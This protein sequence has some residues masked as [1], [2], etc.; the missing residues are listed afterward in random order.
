MKNLYNILEIPNDSSKEEIKKSY[1]KLVVKYH[2]D[3]TNNEPKSTEKFKEIQAAY[4]ILSDEQRRKE[5]DNMNSNERI[6]FDEMFMNFI[7]G[8]KNILLE[9]LRASFKLNKQNMKI[10]SEE[11]YID[12]CMSIDE[13]NELDII[14]DIQIEL[15][16]KYL[17]KKKKIR[18]MRKIYENDKYISKEH[19]ITI[20]L[21]DNQIILYELGDEKYIN[22]N[23]QKGNLIINILSKNNKRYRINE[24]DLIKEVNISLYEYFYGIKFEL[25]HFDCKID[26]NISTPIHNLIHNNDKLL[27]KI[28]KKGLMK[29]NDRG[30]LYIS[31]ILNIKNIGNMDDRE[32]LKYYYPVI[33]K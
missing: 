18:Y 26:I 10:D 5:Y 1:K 31:F 3:K 8:A 9:Y 24:Y 33:T 15:K 25:D 32:L 17:C 2:P 20:N 11:E 27:Y 14:C 28:E 7:N 13:T 4:Q 23:I 29:N 6:L 12:S 16:E 19:E 30:D 22:G 21:N